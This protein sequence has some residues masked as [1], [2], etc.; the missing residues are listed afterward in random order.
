M[1]GL[2]FDGVGCAVTGLPLY[3]NVGTGAHFHPV[4]FSRKNLSLKCLSPLL[5]P[6][7]LSLRASLISPS[8]Y[9]QWQHDPSH[10]GMKPGTMHKLLDDGIINMWW[11]LFLWENGSFYNLSFWIFSDHG[12]CESWP[13]LCQ[14]DEL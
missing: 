10:P 9:Q 8:A 12:K 4:D 13:N 7:Q 14:V 6:L 2:G 1:A 11:G 3:Q 5:L